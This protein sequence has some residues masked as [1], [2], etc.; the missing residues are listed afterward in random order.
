MTVPYSL[1][2]NE[3]LQAI[4]AGAGVLVDVRTASAW[5]GGIP[6]GAQCLTQEAFLA[7]AKIMAQD[8]DHVF[9]ICYRGHTSQ[10]L[11][12]KLNVSGVKKFTSVEGGFQ[13][14]AEQGFPT[15]VPEFDDQDLRY[16]RQTKLK[17]FG[18]AAQAKLK[19]AHVLVVGAGGLGSPALL[20]LAGSGVGKLTLVDKDTVALHNLHRQ[21]LFT[22][23]DIGGSKVKVAKQ[24]LSQLN[25]A[26]QIEV[27]D[28]FLS[29]DNAESLMGD[30]DLILDGSDNINTRYLINEY[31]LKLNKPWVFAAVSGFDVQLTFFSGKPELP[32]YRC[33]FP[34]L[35]AGNIASCSQEGILGP[36]P[37]LA[38][39]LQTTEA[40]KFLT[41]MGHTLQQQM[42]SYDLLN[43]HFKVLKYPA[44]KSESCQH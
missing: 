3:V 20:Y 4:K 36:V 43:H 21:I 14:W 10:Q 16:E 24:R 41:G 31:S 23:A 40:I 25:S 30:V 22:E 12:E 7:T 37:A 2:P 13:A 8:H 18:A 29:A 42:L 6:S 15:E 33:L 38:A 5:S 35:E 19:D 11:A 28:E 26:I 39:M 32:C 27:C 17:G 44:N 1:G 9:I 34:D